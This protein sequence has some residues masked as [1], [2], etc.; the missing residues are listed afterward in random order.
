MY[1]NAPSHRLVTTCLSACGVGGI[2][3]AQKE[4]HEHFRRKRKKDAQVA[5]EWRACR[6]AQDAASDP[7]SRGV[8]NDH[9][10]LAHHSCG[11]GSSVSLWARCHKRFRTTPIDSLAARWFRGRDPVIC[12]PHLA[13]TSTG[14]K[15]FNGICRYLCANFLPQRPE[16]CCGQR[17]LRI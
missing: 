17:T 14:W 5:L 16:F 12:G 13:H 3:A 10:R 1:R 9:V 4:R 11:Q 6:H 8:H 2:S 15:R 7:S